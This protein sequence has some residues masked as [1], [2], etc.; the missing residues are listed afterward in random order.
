MSTDDWRGRIYR[1]RE[2]TTVRLPIGGTGTGTISVAGSGALVDWEIRNS[3]AKNVRPDYAFFLLRTVDVEGRLDVRVLEGELAPPYLGAR[4][5]DGLT[6]GLPRFRVCSFEALYPFARIRLSDPSC[7]LEVEMEVFNPLVPGS[8]DASCLPAAL[9]NFRLVN[10]EER[11]VRATVL[12]VC[13]PLPGEALG[14]AGQNVVFREQGV[15]GVVL[16]HAGA[17]ASDRGRGE[18]GLFLFDGDG[19]ANRWWPAREFNGSLLAFWDEVV[20]HGAPVEVGHDERGAPVATI[21]KE[22]SLDSGGAAT[23]P[24][25]LTWRFPNRAEWPGANLEVRDAPGGIAPRSPELVGNYYAERFADAA[26]V[27]RHLGHSR[28]ELRARTLRFVRSVSES[29]LPPVVSEAALDTLVALRSET[30]FI[31]ADGRLAGWEGCD[32]DVG[33]C[34][35]SC[36]HVWNYEWATALLFGDLARTMRETEMGPALAAN[37]HMSFRIGL[38]PE[39]ARSWELAAADGQMGAIVKL[40]R[41]WA[42]S[43]D[44]AWLARLWPASRRALSYV[45][46]DSGWD[47]EAR[48]VA[49]GCLHHTLDVEYVGPNPLVQFWYLA[50]LRAGAAMARAMR[51]EAFAADCDRRYEEGSRFVDDELFN[52]RY[53]IQRADLAAPGMH[54]GPD[55]ALEHWILDLRPPNLLSEPNVASRTSR[56]EWLRKAIAAGEDVPNQLGDGCLVDQL[57][58]EVAAQLCGLGSLADTRHLRLTAESI[59]RLNRVREFRAAPNFYRT[60]ALNDDAGLVLASYEEA[61]RPR[62]PVPYFT[63]VF[64]GAEYTAAACMVLQGLWDEGLQVVKNVRARHAGWNRNPFDEAECGHHY[65][66]SMASWGVVLAITGFWYR[67]REAELSVRIRGD[68]SRWP[69]SNGYAWGTVALE[70]TA[71]SVEVAI[72]V[73]EGGLA[74]RRV[75]VLDVG[76]TELEVDRLVT[77]GQP[78]HVVVGTAGAAVTGPAR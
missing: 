8:T 61:K 23:V 36:T 40:Y 47:S 67:A 70:R 35:G 25:A 69:W 19:K 21:S 56:S 11:P 71:G 3:P 64:S 33:A 50:A 32:D 30:S 44:D 34:H 2:L 75:V 53:Y 27:A 28:D 5:I 6:A 24:F 4:G 43:G 60:Y 7:P 57:L 51:D 52:G 73:G 39:T 14:L 9:I 78:L 48:G 74:V 12:G 63:E 45:W 1:D 49:D 13:G 41:E 72:S 29:D 37:G 58:G 26:T 17:G 22:T 54:I 59:W 20:E 16:P 77:P 65:A 55:V 31:T 68:R 76:A 15:V 18:L 38:V 42:L 46:G 10:Q 62:V 66:R